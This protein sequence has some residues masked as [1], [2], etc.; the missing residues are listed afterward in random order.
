MAPIMSHSTV[1]Y[2]NDHTFG[3]SRSSGSSYTCCGVTVTVIQWKGLTRS[4]EL[5][6]CEICLLHHPCRR[7]AVHLSF[8]LQQN[9]T[10]IIIIIII[11]NGDSICFSAVSDTGL[12]HKSWLL[13]TLCISRWRCFILEICRKSN[14][15]R[16]Y[17]AYT[18]WHKNCATGHRE[19][20]C[21]KYFTR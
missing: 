1:P 19:S 14:P 13:R 5:I 6:R 11:T 7:R 17:D 15:L 18:G 10:Y 8:F 9:L 2:E 4:P 12:R 3:R 20:K 16:I 21:A